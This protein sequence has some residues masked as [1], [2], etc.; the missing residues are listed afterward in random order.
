[1][2]L[3]EQEKTKIR[4]NW[5]QRKIDRQK[6]IHNQLKRQAMQHMR[7]ISL[8]GS[9]DVCPFNLDQLDKTINDLPVS[10]NEKIIRHKVISKLSHNI[11]GQ[12]IFKIFLYGKAG[13]G[14]TC[15]SQAIMNTLTADNKAVL[16]LNINELKNLAYRSFNRDQISEEIVNKTIDFAKRCDVLILDDLGTESS[17]SSLTYRE[18]NDYIQSMLYEIANERINK[19]TI[20]TSN[21]SRQELQKIYNEKIISRLMPSKNSVPLTFSSFS[22]LR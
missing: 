22:D 3:N 4:A 9:D 21:F 20:I 7:N 10:N 2:D 19:S 1:M 12:N 15:I 17:N 11:T 6:E 8:F 13:T 18:A 5:D 14:K 16:F